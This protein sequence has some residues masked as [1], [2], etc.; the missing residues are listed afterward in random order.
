[1]KPYGIQL[2]AELKGCSPELLNDEKQLKTLLTEGIQKCG[3]LQ[4]NILSHKFNPV[5]VTVISII[6]ESHIAIHTYPE[7]HHASIDIFHCS[8]E[9]RSLFKLLDFLQA[10]LQ[11]QNVK[12]MA[13]ARGKKLELI[14]DNSIGAVAGYHLN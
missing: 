9:A 5:G 10:R 7:A 2:I 14:E 1:M 3:L 12:F 8:A 4:L 6:S 13:I 11:A